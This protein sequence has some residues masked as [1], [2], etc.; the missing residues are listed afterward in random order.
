MDASVQLGIEFP[1]KD[2]ISGFEQYASLGTSKPGTTAQR[3]A[4]SSSFKPALAVTPVL[5]PRIRVYAR[6]TGLVKPYS[7]LGWS[8]RIYD[9]YDT[10]DYVQVS[11]PNRSGIQSFGPTAGFGIAFDT[12]PNANAYLESSYTHPWGRG[13]SNPTRAR[14]SR[15]PASPVSVW[16]WPSEQAWALASKAAPRT[17]RWSQ[18]VPG[19]R[20]S[21]AHPSSRFARPRRV[22]AWT[23]SYFSRKRLQLNARRVSD[24]LIGRARQALKM[25]CSVG[26]PRLQGSR[27][28]LSMSRM[29]PSMRSLT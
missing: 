7:V 21:G 19:R 22:A 14:A 23:G 29:N 16:S 10:P 13:Y 6:P 17:K 5:E 27:R 2:F 28:S 18:R 15:P 26:L 12:H 25:V 9:G 11:Y 1:R 3:T 4:T 20:T 8:M 24:D